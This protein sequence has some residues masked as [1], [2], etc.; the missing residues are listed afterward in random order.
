M[1]SFDDDSMTMSVMGSGEVAYHQWLPNYQ[2][3]ADEDEHQS[4]QRK[5]KELAAL[6]TVNP[7]G[8]SDNADSLSKPSN[9]KP[10]GHN[11][12]H[13][14]PP[15]VPEP[16]AGLNENPIPESTSTSDGAISPMNNPHLVADLEDHRE[17]KSPSPGLDLI[18]DDPTIR[19]P[20]GGE[21]T[22][23]DSGDKG[24]GWHARIIH[25]DSEGTEHRDILGHMERP[26]NSDELI[27]R[28]PTRVDAGDEIGS[29]GNTGGVWTSDGGTQDPAP[30]TPEQRDRGLGAHL[31]HDRS[32]EGVNPITGLPIRIF[33]DPR[34][35]NGD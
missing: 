1:N 34:G 19:A 5:M 28:G 6:E 35:E 8:P 27:Q 31:H 17:W 18:A 21:M 29:M 2:P 13:I 4:F 23:K 30:V 26:D 25:T 11:P 12:D 16:P 10:G 3:H 9:P 7:K 32:H 33:T 14:P 15:V 22:Y 24:Y 20:V